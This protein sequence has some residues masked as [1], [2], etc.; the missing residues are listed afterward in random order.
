MVDG[1]QSDIFGENCEDRD[2]SG[3]ELAVALAVA[4]AL[5]MTQC[6][7]LFNNNPVQILWGHQNAGIPIPSHSSAL[8]PRLSLGGSRH[9]E[10]TSSSN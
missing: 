1:K 8:S 3:K 2:A 9:N 7:R 4:L 10:E 6:D 5:A